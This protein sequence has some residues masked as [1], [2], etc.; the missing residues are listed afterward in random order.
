MLILECTVLCSTEYSPPPPPEDS[1]L[2]GGAGHVFRFDN[3]K[4]KVMK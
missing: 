4:N 1:G 3:I 2:L